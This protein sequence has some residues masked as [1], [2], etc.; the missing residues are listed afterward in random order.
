[1]QEW[2]LFV[3]CHAVR[4]RYLTADA[5]VQFQ[6]SPRRI[7]GGHSG[8]GTGIGPSAVVFPPALFRQ[9]AMVIYPSPTWQRR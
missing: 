4:S 8:I 2:T 3:V 6:S 1:M 7:Y 9:Y 5:P